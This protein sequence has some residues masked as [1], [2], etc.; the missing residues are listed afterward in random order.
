MMIFAI[1]SFPIL[2]DLEESNMLSGFRLL[3]ERA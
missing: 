2:L 1:T 3:A